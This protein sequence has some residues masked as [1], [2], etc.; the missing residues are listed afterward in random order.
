[1]KTKKAGLFCSLAL[2]SGKGGVG[3]T[4]LA[5][6]MSWLLGTSGSKVLIVDLDFQNLGATGLFSALYR[7][8]D[9]NVRD[10]LST[11]GALTGDAA[12][13][14]RITETVSF[15]P[16]AFEKGGPGSSQPA[17]TADAVARMQQLLPQLFDVLHKWHGFDCFVLDCHGGI[18]PIS[19]AAAGVC[20]L[21][22]LV[23]EADTVTFS[24]TLGLLDSYTENYADDERPVVEY[25][26]NRLPPK[27]R[28]RDLDDIYRGYMAGHM[29]RFSQAREILAYIP[30]EDFLA[31]SFGDYPFQVELAPDSLFARKLELVICRLLGESHPR[32]V[33]EEIRERY[34]RPRVLKRVDRQVLSAEA[35]TVRA[36]FNTYGIAGLYAL[37]FFPW[38]LMTVTAES[39]GPGLAASDNPFLNAAQYIMPLMLSLGVI[40][41]AVLV[42]VAFRIFRY[43]RG[44][45]RF[46]RSM[47]RAA[48][49]HRTLWRRLD[50]WKLRLF[51]YASALGPLLFLVYILPIGASV[52]FS[53]LQGLTFLADHFGPM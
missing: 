53:A 35:Q 5:T 21:T 22:L 40:L 20:D 14:A 2:V 8:P 4:T 31:D 34:A 10:L 29:G 33:S 50:L 18:D 6:N 47:I 25:V 36:V 32:L 16:A 26:I 12:P 23:T 28:W 37:L 27:Y 39:Q 51:F 15:L 46:T 9:T 38:A 42:R 45:L 44:R 41:L 30:S 49:S 48:P 3:K 17:V 11:P 1:M 52:V 43:F 19:I 7:L 24:G 13:I